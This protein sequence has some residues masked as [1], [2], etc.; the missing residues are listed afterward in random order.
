MFDMIHSNI[1]RINCGE[2]ETDRIENAGGLGWQSL[3]L[4]LSE[5]LDE[6]KLEVIAR[7]ECFL[8]VVVG[9]EFFGEEQ[10]A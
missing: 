6:W 3:H 10:F 4:A 8:Q 2:L 5:F 9:E 7:S 1:N